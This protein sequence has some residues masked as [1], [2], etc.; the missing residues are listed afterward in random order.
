M[1]TFIDF[2]NKTN[3]KLIYALRDV[4]GLGLSTSQRVCKSLGYDIN[5]K[6]MDF[7]SEDLNKLTA[8]V[9]VQYKFIIGAEL[10]KQTYDKIQQM[11]NIRCY[12][13]VRHSYNLPV[14]GQRTHTNAKTRG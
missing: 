11:K 3:K 2:N 6:L 12:K 5:T 9:S 7:R 13:G 1:S 4:Y 8:I 10:K 14:N